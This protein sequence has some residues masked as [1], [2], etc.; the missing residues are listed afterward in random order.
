MSMLSEV[1]SALRTVYAAC[2]DDFLAT[3]AATGWPQ[4]LVDHLAFAVKSAKD[5]R[6][7]RNGL[8]SVMQQLQQ[9]QGLAR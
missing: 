7:L 2:G 8:K 5:Q 4:P 9:V 3:V 6:E 1:A